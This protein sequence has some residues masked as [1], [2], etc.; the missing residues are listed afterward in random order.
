MAAVALADLLVDFGARQ[1]RA[2][3]AVPSQRPVAV[4]PAQPSVGAMV[5]AEVARAEAALEERL[6]KMHSADLQAERERHQSE[7]AALQ[8]RHGAEMGAAIASACEV[9]EQ[10][11]SESVTA[12]VTRILA[13]LMTQDLSRRSVASLQA[14]IAEAMRDRG[15]VRIVVSGP[16]PLCEGVGAALGERA[17][18]VEFRECEGLDLAVSVDGGLL[19]TRIGEWSAMLGEIVP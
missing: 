19:E 5:A 7:I 14:M 18:S 9:L 3:D 16:A 4:A 1:M 8:L 13:R 11:F 6:S 2:A 15:S 10:R 12:P 17:A